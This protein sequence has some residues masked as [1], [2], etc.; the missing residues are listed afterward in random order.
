ME[1]LRLLCDEGSMSL[2]SH[3][4]PSMIQKY[5][6]MDVPNWCVIFFFFYPHEPTM[7]RRKKRAKKPL[8]TVELC[9]MELVNLGMLK[10]VSIGMT[11][12]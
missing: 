8:K 10:F 6:A 4:S 12:E 3:L 11:Y 5:P 7:K 2:S 1:I 9:N